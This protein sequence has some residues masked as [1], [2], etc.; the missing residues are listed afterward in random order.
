MCLARAIDRTGWHA[1]E[2]GVRYRLDECPFFTEHGDQR[3]SATSLVVAKNARNAVAEAGGRH[4]AV[5]VAI[6][7][8]QA[9]V[10]RS[11]IAAS[12]AAG[13]APQRL[14]SRAAG[15]SSTDPLGGDDDDLESDADGDDSDFWE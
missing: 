10:V 15:S 4:K 14:P 2:W 13:N 11:A 3:R 5:G 8:A 12:R 1:E 6:A 7:R 9:E